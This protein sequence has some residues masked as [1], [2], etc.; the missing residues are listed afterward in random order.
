[1]RLSK[2]ATVSLEGD[3]I[4]FENLAHVSVSND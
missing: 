1:M 3:R 4:Y 2:S